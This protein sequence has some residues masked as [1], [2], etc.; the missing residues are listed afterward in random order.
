MMGQMEER[1]KRLLAA[2]ASRQR[3]L[4]QESEAAVLQVLAGHSAQHRLE[5]TA[6]L[7]GH[8]AS[9]GQLLQVR[10]CDRFYAPLIYRFYGS[11]S[12]TMIAAGKS[13]RH[14]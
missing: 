9:H 13:R 2:Q 4:L 7:E 3:A 10:V 8:L 1:F 12:I 6:A 5:L 11:Y 14:T